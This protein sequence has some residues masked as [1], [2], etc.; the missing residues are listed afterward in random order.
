MRRL[1]RGLRT[2]RPRPRRLQPSEPRL[3][4]LA[5]WREAAQRHGRLLALA[6]EARAEAATACKPKATSIRQWA[7]Q[8]VRWWDA[9][10]KRALAR[11]GEY[12]VSAEIAN[13]QAELSGADSDAATEADA[14]VQRAAAWAAWAGEVSESAQSATDMLNECIEA[15]EVNDA[16]TAR[17]AAERARQADQNAKHVL[18]RER[19]LPEPPLRA[20]L[21]APGELQ[22]LPRLPRR[23][24]WR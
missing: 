10:K 15:C 6:E 16:T 11:A 19:T 24:P 22:Y 1:I 8:R 20:Q 4:P 3:D 2:S 18:A 14:A 17:E 21:R 9:T 12:Y 13:I 5:R 23:W 7:E